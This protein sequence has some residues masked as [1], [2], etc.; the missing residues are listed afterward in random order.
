MINQNVH[1][2]EDSKMTA[3]IPTR[4]MRQEA[5][6]FIPGALTH[7]TKSQLNVHAQVYVPLHVGEKYFKN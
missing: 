5:A 3:P 1:T 6:P 7:I 2:E 4:R